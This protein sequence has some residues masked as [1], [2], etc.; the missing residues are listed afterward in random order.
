MV[1]ILE[2]ESDM[3]EITLSVKLPIMLGSQFVRVAGEAKMT[4]N[5][6]LELLVRRAVYSSLD[7]STAEPPEPIPTRQPTR[8]DW[9]ELIDYARR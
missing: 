3:E 4:P 8:E 7:H 6:L 1:K 9:A 2:K 5:E